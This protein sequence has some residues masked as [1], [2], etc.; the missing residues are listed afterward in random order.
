MAV[1]ALLWCS[2]EPLGYIDDLKQCIDRKLKRINCLNYVLY[3]KTHTEKDN[4]KLQNLQKATRRSGTSPLAIYQ[5]HLVAPSKS[6]STHVTPDTLSIPVNFVSLSCN[7]AL[8]LAKLR[9]VRGHGTLGWRQQ[10]LWRTE[11][12]VVA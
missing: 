7:L 9:Q 2:N 3:W 6:E 10:G 11:A 4:I 12:V 1:L 5:H 8:I